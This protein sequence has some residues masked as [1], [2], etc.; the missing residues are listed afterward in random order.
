MLSLLYYG[1]FLRVSGSMGTYIY[2]NKIVIL[3]LVHASQLALIKI[4]LSF[5]LVQSERQVADKD[6]KIV[7]YI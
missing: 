2:P 1:L 7:V 3:L 4:R 5:T 6:Y